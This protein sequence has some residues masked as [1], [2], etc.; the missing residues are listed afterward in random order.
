VQL[1]PAPQ[2]GSSTE[3]YTLAIKTPGSA[4]WLAPEVRI[5]LLDNGKAGSEAAYEA[6]STAAKSTAADVWS[7]GLVLLQLILQ[8]GR[9]DCSMED[10]SAANFTLQVTLCPL[11]GSCKKEQYA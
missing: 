5:F 3:A 10:V 9:K 11:H 7:V 2:E 8:L 4:P 1:P 6:A